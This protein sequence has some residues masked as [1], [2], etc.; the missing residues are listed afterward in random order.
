MA[1]NDPY[2]A[3]VSLLLHC[4]GADNGTTFTDVTGKTVTRYNAVTKTATKKYGTA[5]G[6]FD[7]TGDYLTAPDSADFA[8]GSG[9]FTIECW[10]KLGS[11]GT[12]KAFV[13]H[14]DSS[15]SNFAWLFYTSSSNAVGL[16]ISTSGT[17][18]AA[19]AYKSYTQ[20]TTEWHHV[21]AVRSGN[22]LRIYLDGVAGGTDADVTGMSIYDSTTVIRVGTDWNGSTSGNAMNGYLDD[23][24]ITKGVA[25]YTAD[26]TPPSAA[27]GDYDRYLAGTITE[28]TDHTDFVVRAHR[29]DTGAL[30]TELASTGGAYEIPIM[31]SGAG[32]VGPVMLSAYQ[33]LGT[34]WATNTAYASGAYVFPPDPATDPHVFA[35]TTAG[36]SDATTEPT[37]DTTPGNTTSDGTVTWTCQGRM[38]QPLLQGPLIPSI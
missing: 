38:V 36:T 9:D 23:I 27:F 25:R 22:T 13:S 3:D 10:F 37:W 19:I 2:F 7:G 8:L 20:E 5:S 21:A 35:C 30:I 33:K 11:T 29:L 6:Y 28:D 24:R 15:T 1:A 17:S 12:T 32:Y 31:V 4:D 16:S 18:Q 14:R 26:F 34:V